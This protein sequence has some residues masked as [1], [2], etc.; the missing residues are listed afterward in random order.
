MTD[1]QTIIAGRTLGRYQL[2]A[3]IARG[4]PGQVWLGRVQ[5]ARGFHKLV[6]VKTLLAP[7]DE[8]EGMM[9]EEARIASLIH[10]ANVVQTIELGEDAGTLYLVMEWVDGEP[11][12][13]VMVK[14]QE[15][16]GLP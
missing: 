8:A 5:G 2:L 12:S 10:H 16:G 1:S 11:L 9:L 4:G 15:R 14:A 7:Q 3:S 6:A 13:Q